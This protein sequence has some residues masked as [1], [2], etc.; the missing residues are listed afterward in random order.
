M[1][2]AD[3]ILAD[4]PTSYWRLSESGGTTIIDQLGINTGTYANLPPNFGQASLVAGGDAAL[5]VTTSSVLTFGNIFSFT[6]LSPFSLEIWMR[7]SDLSS[8]N[9]RFFSAR[10]TDGNGIQGYEFITTSNNQ[11][12]LQRFL[13]GGTPDQT[14][15]Q[16]GTISAGFVYHVV[17]T[18]DGTDM[19]IY[20]NGKQAATNPSSK[21]IAANVGPFHIA[22]FSG[23]G[24][25]FVGVLDEAAVYSY[26][27]TAGQVAYHYAVGSITPPY[28]AM[29]RGI[30]V[31]R[32]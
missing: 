23:G 15:T 17:G 9:R 19:R 25:A 28:P 21:S 26:A 6:G 2:Y 4:V 5:G 14:T 10:A 31:R 18:Y 24:N 11:I 27:L 7:A 20:I 3:V 30:F 22:S 1:G 13:N 16:L 29:V 8:F 12:A 32:G